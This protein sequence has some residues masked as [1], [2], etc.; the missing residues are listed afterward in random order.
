MPRDRSPSG[1]RTSDESAVE[2]FYGR[3]AGLYD[4]LATRTPGIRDVRERT[5]DA[6]GLSPGETVVEMGCG[7][8][9]NLDLLRE[10]VGAEGRV[11]GVDL[12]PGMLMRAGRRIRRAGWR[13][14]GL[15]RA[16]AARPPVAAADAV[17]ATFVVGMLDEPG[18]AVGGWADIV[19][20][21]GRVALLDAAPRGRSGALDAAFRLFVAATAPPTFRLRY[22]ESPARSLGRRVEAARAALGG[23]SGLATDERFGRGFLRLAVGEVR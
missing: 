8:G 17:L 3:W 1:G 14:V 7:T 18:E 22:A 16:D 2:R 20:P 15:L 9:A 21:G 23:R 6:L 4:V 12:T 5:V 10:R 11:V 19:G 13:N